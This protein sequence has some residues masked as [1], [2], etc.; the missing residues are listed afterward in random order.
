MRVIIYLSLVVLIASAGAVSAGEGDGG[1][2]GAFFQVPAGARPTGMGGAYLA[3][4]DDGAAPLFNPAGVANRT[5]PLFG[6]S[7]R[8][9]QLDRKL[10]YVTFLYPVRGEAVIGGHWLY[11]GSGSVEA[12]NNDG[13]LSG[14]EI[15]Q[16]N[17]QFTIIFA[18]RFERM[19]A[20][21]ANLD[22]LYSRMA[23]MSAAS[24]GFD[25]GGMFYLEQLFDRDRRED[26]FVRDLQVG[27]T[28]RNITK[29]YS[30]NSEKYNL[31][32]DRS[33]LGVVQDDQVPVEF[34]LGISG[35]LFERKLLLASDLKKNEKQ[36]AD[37][38]AGAEYYLTQ[39]F[40]LRTGYSDG[41]FTAGTGYLFQFGKAVLLIDYAF[42]T[43][44]ADE[45]SEHIF[46]VDVQ[47]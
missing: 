31:E 34:G 35:R 43:D 27:V 39:E 19:F 40:A 25:L 18:K 14:F 16:N 6:S 44:K 5:R 45:G 17:H 8:V 30:W 28:L 4:S 37:F 29:K 32:H 1:Y 36:S 21:G 41:R 33:A 11:A 13:Y 23:E 46:S 47:F 12:R 10:G 7:Y 2:A 20:V 3:I 22:Y 15:S 26:L 9:M 42:T 38:H 24:V